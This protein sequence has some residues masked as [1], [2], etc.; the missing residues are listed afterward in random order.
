MLGSLPLKDFMQFLTDL[1]TTPGPSL[2]EKPRRL[3][4]ESFLN[5][6]GVPTET[7][8]ADNLWVSLGR[9]EI[10]E[11]WCDAVVYDAHIDV[12]ERGYVPEVRCEKENLIGMGVGDNLTA[13]AMLAFLAKRV[14]TERILLKRPLKLLF[15]VGEEG[16]GNLKGV[17]RVVKDHPIPPYLF[18][19]FDLSFEEYS[20]T[21]LGSR[22][23]CVKVRCP[24]GHSWDDFGSP[25]AIEQIIGLLSFLKDACINIASENQKIISFNI[26]SIRGGEGINSIARFAE[27]AF[28]FRSP[29]PEMLDKMAHALSDLLVKIKGQ[30]GVSVCHEIIGER[31]AAQ[32]VHP[33][34]IEPII[35]RLLA[36]QG[37][38]PSC[39]TRSTNI[40]IPLSAGWPSI[41]MGLCRCGRYHSEEEYVE[42]GSLGQGWELLNNLTKKLMA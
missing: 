5:D 41:C 7:D 27:A 12:V 10:N 36:E 20:I 34:R 4:L 33:E 2:Q 13:V 17:R 11:D 18:I 25:N 42:I 1:A 8:P 39:S 19:A 29:F 40:N 21:G 26:G 30:K 3:L 16:S 15:S 28:E 35:Y 9:D 32:A 37:E 23:Y 24:G 31:P 6:A 14:T 38:N 22:R